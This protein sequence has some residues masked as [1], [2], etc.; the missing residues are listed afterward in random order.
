MKIDINYELNSDIRGYKKAIRI[1]NEIIKSTHNDIIVDFK[2][3]RWIDSSLVSLIGSLPRV[4]K[5]TYNKDV[6]LRFKDSTVSLKQYIQNSGLANFYDSKNKLANNNAIP[7]KQIT[8]EEEI[9]DVVES[10]LNL[11]PVTLK[12]ELYD[13]VFSKLYEMFINSLEHSYSKTGVF[14]CGHWM[15]NKKIL[16]FSIYDAGVGIPYN[17]RKYEN[18]PEILASCALEKSVKIGYSTKQGN[19]GYSR[20]LGL[21]G[22]IDFIKENNGEIYIFSENGYC[23]INRISTVFNELDIPIE[24]TLISMSIRT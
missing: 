2:N 17:I 9:P 6:K 14:C 5:Q 22:M 16:R 3:C 10:I 23:N 12:E 20:G 13:Q 8:E 24:G 18:S 4:S 1:Q 21:Y 11:S 19:E 15:P 7:F